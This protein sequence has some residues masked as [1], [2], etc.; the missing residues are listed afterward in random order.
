MEKY[1]NNIKYYSKN[2]SWE[3][4]RKINHLEIGNDKIITKVEIENL[5][6]ET[7]S[8]IS[9]AVRNKRF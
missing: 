6:F 7:Y 3:M 9:K 2:K 5:L 8:E 4:I 1:V